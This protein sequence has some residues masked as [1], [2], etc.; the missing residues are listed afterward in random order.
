VD[1]DELKLSAVALLLTSSGTV[2]LMTGFGFLISGSPVGP[3]LVPI[4]VVLL[5]AGLGLTWT[6][7]WSLRVGHVACALAVP[8]W[9]LSVATFSGAGE[10]ALFSLAMVAVTAW[11]RRFLGAELRGPEWKRRLRSDEVSA[12]PSR[13]GWIEDLPG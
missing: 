7:P 5:V 11:A 10:I 1:W 3:I 8:V 4:A 9:L 12:A 6:R 2:A 13:A